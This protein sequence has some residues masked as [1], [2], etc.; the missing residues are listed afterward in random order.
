MALQQLN[1]FK[2]PS[3][4]QLAQETLE[5]YE[6]QLLIQEAAAAYHAKMAE[7]YREGI[8]RLAKPQTAQKA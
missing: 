5:D 8:N 2:K 1:P 3:A 7:F 6:R 4:A